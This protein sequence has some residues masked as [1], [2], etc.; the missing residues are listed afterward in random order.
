[1]GATPL[2]LAAVRAR[3]P[4]LARPLAYLDGP[5]GTQV[6]D[7]VIEAIAA[8]LRTSNANTGGAFATS[9]E[10]DALVERARAAAAGFLGC[11]PEEVGFGQNATTLSFALSRTVGRELAA[12]DEVVV[13][14][15]D[16]DANVAP[17]LELAHDRGIVVRLA[18]LRPED[19]TLDLDDLAAQLGPRTRVVAFPWAA[20]SLGTVQD[21]ARI[22][23]LAHEAGALAWC[24][25]VHMAPHGPMDVRAAGVDVLLY[26]AYKAFGP[27][28]GVFAARRELLERWRPYKVRPADEEPAAHRHETG[29]L[30]H[31]LLAGY[32]ASVEYLAGVGWDAIVAHERALGE[33]LLAGLP[34]RYRLWGR[35][36]MAGRVPTFCVTHAAVHPDEVARRLAARG[37]A[38]WSG[39]YY[40][41]EP[42]HRLG[43]SDGAV[44]IGLVHYTSPDE[45]DR[46]LEEL[47]R[48]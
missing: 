22:A 10:T 47:D 46:L 40:A 27:H 38:V 44:R 25:G 35:P 4:A 9:V 41:L 1:M 6:P 8:Y 26:S 16:H 42:M 19:G 21:V 48:I 5:A 3:F 15:L 39:D 7:T 33:R 37:I 2:D 24:D 31:E 17:W 11:A 43:L 13:T 18:D 29:T 23:E 30:A 32:V 14:R 20:N 36:D 34:D 45:V 28:L 12:G